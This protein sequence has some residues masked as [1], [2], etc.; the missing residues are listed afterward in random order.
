MGFIPR[1][2]VLEIK[3]FGKEEVFQFDFSKYCIWTFS[4]VNLL[5]WITF[6]FVL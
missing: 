6:N 4:E 2:L 3:L 5:F 1:Y